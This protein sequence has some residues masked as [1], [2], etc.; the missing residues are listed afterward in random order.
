MA[1]LGVRWVFFVAMALG[2]QARSEV[3]PAQLSARI[4]RAQ[5]ANWP[6]ANFEITLDGCS[7]TYRETKYIHQRSNFIITVWLADFEPEPTVHENVQ[8][9]QANE[10]VHIPTSRVVFRFRGELV[11]AFHEDIARYEAAKASIYQKVTNFSGLARNLFSNH[12]PESVESLQAIEE[13]HE[14]VIAGRFG[15]FLQ[16]NYGVGF[17]RELDRSRYFHSYDVVKSGISFTLPD[18]LMGGIL[19]DIHQYRLENCPL[20][21]ILNNTPPGP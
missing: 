7:L 12:D 3:D 2:S 5:N 6:A 17:G 21:L 16:R 4:N 11:E 10:T 14:D 20:G 8:R 18:Y 15:P 9:S 1:G 19:E 13:L